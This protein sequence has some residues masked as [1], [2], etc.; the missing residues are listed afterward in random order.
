MDYE[1]AA[2]VDL[3]CDKAPPTP[4]VL[5]PEIKHTLYIK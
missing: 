5:R 2:E 1:L 3:V 4:A